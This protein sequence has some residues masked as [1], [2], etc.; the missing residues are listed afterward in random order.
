MSRRALPD[1]ARRGWCPGLARPMP[2]G[3]GLLARIHPPLGVLTLAQA[4]AIAEGARRWGNGHLD[5]T[6]R[7]NLQIRG[8][9]EATR[10]ELAGLLEAAGLGDTRTDGGPQRLTL[11]GPLAGHDPAEVIDVPALARAIETAGRGIPGLPAK[12]LVAVGIPLADADL[13]IT[14]LEDGTV[15]IALAGGDEAGLA[16]PLGEAVSRVASLLKGFAESGSRRIRD[17]T[18]DERALLIAR[19]TSPDHVPPPFAGE[20]G[21]RRGSGEGSGGAGWGTACD[22]SGTVTPLSPPP[23][24]GPLPGKGGRE[25]ASLAPGLS[26][27]GG[28]R[29]LALDAPFGRCTADAFTR[30]VAMA[31]DIGASEIR[32]SPSRGII[33][34]PSRPE[35]AAVRLVHR[36]RRRLQPRLEKLMQ[37]QMPSARSHERSECVRAL[38]ALST[39]FIT[40]AD[41][42]RR[43]VAACTGAPACASGTTPTLH[44]ASRL[45]EAFRPFAAQGLSAHVSG[46]AKG[47]AK[48]G[49][50]DLT[51]VGKDGAYAIIVAGSPGDPTFVH[52][53]IEAVLERL[54]RAA[55]IGLAAAFAPAAIDGG[56]NRRPA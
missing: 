25:G 45:A 21:P 20:G 26:D 18:A 42:P 12:T 47:C 55:T 8:V 39:D 35:R 11:T 37:K 3:D 17:L 28:L 34:L 7:A 54:G 38:G 56:R 23:T 53:P 46:C 15:A 9:S 22:L 10:A 24:Q 43:A 51:L 4:R 36:S 50:A 19:A 44:D 32:L 41:D 14:A 49:P 33:L 30:L 31:E 40:T 27:H 6:A 5:L 16:C 13:A 52:I 1:G 2:T 48:P 29:V